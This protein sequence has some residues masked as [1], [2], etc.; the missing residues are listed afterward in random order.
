MIPAA[1]PHREWYQQLYMDNNTEMLSY[2]SNRC[3]L[4]I[5]NYFFLIAVPCVL[6]FTH[7]PREFLIVYAKGT[8]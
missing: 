3:T 1:E 5:N 6:V 4:Y 2:L 8:N 7:H